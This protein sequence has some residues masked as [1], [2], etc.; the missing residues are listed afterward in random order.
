MSKKQEVSNMR[1]FRNIVLCFILVASSG[2]AQQFYKSEGLRLFNQDEYRAAIDSMVRWADAHTAEQ[3]IAFYYVGESYYNLGLDEQLPTRSLSHYREGARYFDLAVRQPDLA[4]LHTDKMIA[5]QYK[6]SWCRYRLA[7]LSENPVPFLQTAYNGFVEVA[8]SQDDSLSVMAMYMAGEARFN[9]AQ[10]KRVQMFLTENDGVI[11]DLAREAIGS[12]RESERLF[13]QV[14]DNR[15]AD[16]RLRI[17]ARIRYQDV[18]YERAKLYERMPSAVFSRLDDSGKRETPVETAVNI[19]LQIDYNSII[20]RMDRVSGLEFRPLIAYSN[21]VKC[22]SL[23]QLTGENQNELN[24]NT[25]LDSLRWSDFQ[26]EKRF[27][28]ASRDQMSAIDE[29][30]YLTLTDPQRS[31]YTQVASD[32]SEAWYWL[33]WSQ[34]VA[35]VGAEQ[36]PFQQFL[37]SSRNAVLDPRTAVL[38]DDAQYRVFML[39]FDQH[40]ADRGVLGTMKQEIENFHPKHPLIQRRKELLLQLVRIG[41][42]ETIWGRILQAPGDAERFRDAFGLIRNM[43]VR[44]NRVTGRERVPYL[45]Y[46]DQLFQITEDRRSEATMFYRGMAQFLRAEIQESAQNKR[47]YY[48]AAGEM[49]QEATGDY[50][51][52]AMY[53]QARSYFAAAKHESD[54]RQRKRLHDRAK[55]LFIQLINEARSLRSVYYLGEI[56]RIQGNGEAARRCYDVVMKRTRG[57]AGGAFWYGNA[58]AGLESSGSAG[59]ASALNNVRIDQVVFPERLLIVDGEEI[60]LERFADPDYVRKQYWEEAIDMLLKFGFPKLTLYPSMFRNAQSRYSQRT[61]KN[62]TAGIQERIG[63]ISS[64]LKLI[65]ILPA[66]IPQR[67]IATL[68]GVALE[69]SGMGIF[70]KAPLSMNSVAEIRIINDRCYP[71]V[72]QHRFTKP[73]IEEMVVSLSPKSSFIKRGEGIESGVNVV[74]LSHRLDGNV[75]LHSGHQALSASTILYR[76]IYSDISYRDFAYAPALEGYVVVNSESKNLLLYR[77]DPMVSKEGEFDL[78]FGSED[79]GLSSPEG[80]AVDSQGNIYVADWGN[81]RICVF[82]RDGHLLRTFGSLGRNTSQNRGKP[83]QFVFPTRI[84]VAEDIQGV[85]TEGRRVRRSPQFYVADRQG[86]HLMDENGN[87]LDTIVSGHVAMGNFY[88]LTVRGYGSN[89]RL[90]VMNRRTGRIERFIAQSDGSD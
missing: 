11:T 2:L 74:D 33:G 66:G 45:N 82:G 30:S 12:L 7:E 48:L 1:I 59:D 89:A 47:Q 52:E 58:L 79:D 51:S 38:R 55:P 84:A 40:A 36:N 3:G 68:D 21:A 64:G 57:K 18:L 88:G 62:V 87:Y 8:S 5:A 29:D 10:W 61:F 63:S 39:R 67:V 78:T 71:F 6:K 46:L 56:F 49:L 60:S 37:N 70:Q 81:H 72:E 27:M 35:G 25:A 22:L 23:F 65:V 42:G 80:I 13:Q 83:I 86:V 28:L 17:S 32:I 41:L 4:S 69:S 24:L 34:F 73:G 14:G 50:R 54:T 15:V 26:A 31:L 44:A 75:V 19:L 85:S 77:N 53:I 9:E 43:M 76:D 20:N 90:Y 16:S